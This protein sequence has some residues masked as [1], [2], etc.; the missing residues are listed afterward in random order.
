[1][2]LIKTFVKDSIQLN[3]YGTFEKPLFMAKEIG[4]IL[5]MSNINEQIRLIE[6]DWKEFRKTETL[7]DCR[8][9][10]NE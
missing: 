4:S 7:G 8:H 1:M 9:K 5:N 3:V 2:E 10:E 6:S